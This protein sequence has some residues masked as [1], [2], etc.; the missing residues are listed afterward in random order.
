MFVSQGSPEDAR[1]HVIV[2]PT[3]QEG[4]MLIPVISV[5]VEGAL[6]RSIVVGPKTCG[7]C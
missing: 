2:T 5:V 4:D 3:V 7:A 1:T 6:P